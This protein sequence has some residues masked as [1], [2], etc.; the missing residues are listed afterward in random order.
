MGSITLGPG[1]PRYWAVEYSVDGQNWSENPVL[2]YTVPDFVDKANRRVFQL[3]GTKYI[4]VNLPD[5][6]LGQDKVYVRLRPTSTRGGTAA[7]YEGNTIIPSDRYNAINYV[8]IRY[9]NN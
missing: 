6:F 2:Q 9:N 4:T 5:E 3:P 7:S 8:A 1:A